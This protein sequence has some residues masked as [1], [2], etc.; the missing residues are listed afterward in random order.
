M[1]RVSLANR[2]SKIFGRRRARRITS[3]LRLN[4]ESC[5]PRILLA[6]L[7]FGDGTL[8][9]SGDAGEAD[10][11]IV[12]APDADTLRIV[13]GGDDEIVL[14]AG[15]QGAGFVL[16]DGNQA[17]EV[18]VG[19]GGVAVADFEVR[20]GDGDD[21]VSI[22][23]LPDAVA[24]NV[25]AAEGDD[26]VDA[27]GLAQSFAAV[28][29][30]GDDTLFGGAGS[31]TLIG[32]SG[33]DELRGGGGDDHLVGGGQIEIT[34]TNLQPEEGALLTPVF[35]A[36]GNGQ[37][38]FFDVGS[39][40]SA[41]L[42]RLAED[43]NTGPRIEAAL[44]SGGV[45]QAVS[46]PGGP[47]AP[48]ESRTISLVADSSNDLTQYL[49]YASMV[50]PSN[51]AFIGNDD[52]R[53]IDLFDSNG[54]LIRR[55]G[56]GAVIVGG[57]EVWDAGT[58]AND[59]IP[60]NTAALAQAAPDTGTT[61]GGVV[62]Q[63]PGF[64]GSD[65]LG[66]SVGN[67]LQARSAADFT[68]A[69]AQVVSIGVDANDGGDLLIGGD[70]NDTLIGGSGDDELI[71]G[72]GSDDL[73]GGAGND[74]L[75][76]GGQIQVTVTNLQPENGAL[77][78]PFFLATG[79]GSYDFFNA[80]SPAS[81]SLERL[82]EDGNTGPRTEVALGS[83]GVYEALTTAGGPLAPGDSRSLSFSAATSNPLS[84]YLSYA[85]MVIPS[86]DAFIGNDDPRTLDL[87]TADG[88]LIERQGGGAFIVAGADVW[89]AGT[90]VNDEVPENT[91]ALAQAAP[92]TGVDEG[93]VVQLHG[94]F[95]G[96]NALGGDLGNVL[97][98]RAA[99]D[100]TIPGVEIARIEVTA[101]DG[102]D[103]LH[104]GDGD[105]SLRG[106]AGDDTLVGGAG[107]DELRGGTGDDA[108]EGGGSIQVTVTNLQSADG[109]LLTPVFLATTDGG[110]DFFDA[111][112]AA[113][114]SLERLAEDGNTG[115][116]IDAALA[117]GGVHQ[118]TNTPAGPLAPGDSRSI[119]LTAM[120]FNDLTQ[121][122]SFA[123]MVIPSND[124]FLGN[125]VPTE[126][127]LFD[128]DGRLIE[129]TADSAIV[130]TG[131]EVWDAGTEVNDE[132]PENTAALAQAAPDTGVTEGGV[133]A[134]HPG[135]Q[136]SARFGGALGNIL[137]A[138]AAA[139]FTVPGA[140][141]L[142][143]EIVG[144]NGV[145]V[146]IEDPPNTAPI[147]SDPGPLSLPTTQDTLDIV[148][149][150]TDVDAGAAL[151]F[152]ATPR[153]GE[154]FLDQSLDL[155]F[156]GDLFLNNGGL[157][158]KWVLAGDQIT[159]HYITPSGA[160]YEWHGGGVLNRTLVAQLDTATYDDPARLYDA[161]P[162]IVTSF[163]ATV[164]G[165]TL[166]VN[167]EAGFVGLVAVEI[168]VSDGDLTDSILVPID[169]LSNAAPTLADPGSQTVATSQ[170]TLDV[171]LSATDPNGD[172]LTYSAIPHSGEYYFDQTIGLNLS[173]D[174]FLNWSG[175]LNEKWVLSDNQQWYFITPD[176]NFW[177][178]LGGDRNI[179][180][181]SELMGT[182]STA[183][184]DDPALLYDAQPGVVVPLTVSVAGSTL[185][186][187]PADGTVGTLSVL[188]TTTDSGGLE[189]SRLIRVD[190]TPAPVANTLPL[191]VRVVIPIQLDRDYDSTKEDAAAKALAER[192]TGAIPDRDL[193]VVPEL[194][195]ESQAEVNGAIDA[196]HAG[197]LLDDPDLFSDDW[198]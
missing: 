85:S 2:L 188:V 197:D 42:E 24:L 113:S 137:Q 105:D 31:D 164:V 84:Q 131:G 67:I 192:S 122:L 173:S 125:D 163:T 3:R 54:D 43:G 195:D 12:S 157:N 48:G 73:D 133:I 8:A 196:V 141:L 44:Q 142:R 190:V 77:L 95:Q 153:S 94:G 189:D 14:G 116:R 20:L 146:L 135:F 99:A 56:A 92:N 26:L 91:A 83:G 51:D 129:R 152:T 109:A 23:S 19:D 7:T 55:T 183:T 30:V 130:V 102:N 106:G 45:H 61:E 107:S 90:E 58:E 22:S 17:V 179:A 150:A 165:N 119:V 75:D 74:L 115:P 80:G 57:D 184:Y 126:I 194:T 161:Q 88:E 53:Q 34:V 25:D 37:Y 68:V 36:T 63:H 10:E 124:A 177:R 108:L 86:N 27:T 128:A 174:L 28:G 114:A 162:D 35:L 69:G 198:L 65:R 71:G 185:T 89:D 117:S 158:E 70:G 62:F 111:G 18:N 191:A 181:N 120:N 5:E 159:W 123:T 112:D 1:P 147:V 66:G 172:P 16:S 143:I 15:S 4:V 41:S 127:D 154:Y 87:F 64:Q 96:S 50:I 79:N 186:I 72:A 40:A 140:E 166:T 151:V 170:D 98:A 76:G 139:D 110:Y 39:P 11:I 81:A 134:Q 100:F 52:P 136:G 93:G 178:W 59:E 9:L 132:I 155:N 180:E 149:G 29:G 175:S 104:G 38:D 78:T 46:T 187:D 171:E 49:S 145:D 118:A 97:E 156:T 182:L 103:R 60:A 82:A 13:V 47:L 138:R 101:D 148:L 33:S 32:G 168:T 176:G 167:P 144:L 6:S 121:Y 169:V 160:F 21:T 193:Y